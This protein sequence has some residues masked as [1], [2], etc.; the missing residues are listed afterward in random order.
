MNS[1]SFNL[2]RR[3]LLAYLMWPGLTAHA[4]DLETT[5]ATPLR[6]ESSEADG[7]I[8]GSVQ[9]LSPFALGAVSEALGAPTTWCEIL[10]L[11]LNNKACRLDPAASGPAIALSIARKHD[12]AVHNAHA[13]RLQWQLRESTPQRFVVRLDAPDGPFG[14]KD[15]VVLLTAEPA[16]GGQTSIAFSY[17]CRFGPAARMAL[18]TYLA[19]LGRDKV[20]FTT[21][22]SSNGPRLVGGLRGVVERTAMRYYLAIDAW[23]QTAALEPMQRPMA[24]LET[25]FDATE[26]YPRQLHELDRATYLANKRRE[27]GI[28]P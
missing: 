1:R 11:H 17:A 9:A 18:Q 20:G 26:R 10:M 6:I 3:Q 5:T 14:T 19:T 21:V 13:L 24:R 7:E 8:K 28:A 16:P 4:A 25:W 27:L 22:V 15:Y 12:L 2:P 23:L